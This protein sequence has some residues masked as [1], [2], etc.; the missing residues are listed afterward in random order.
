MTTKGKHVLTVTGHGNPI[1]GVDWIYADKE[2]AAFV[3]CSQDQTAMIWKWNV[4]N[5]AADCVHIC[6][7]HERSVDCI[8]ASPDTKRF[9]TGS[10]DPMLK[11]CSINC[12]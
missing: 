4:D 6:K 7:G 9:A 12:R 8:A 1:K 11:V 10:W 3:S 2:N 5:N